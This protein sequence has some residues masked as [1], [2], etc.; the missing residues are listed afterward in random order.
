M[1]TGNCIIETGNENFS[2]VF[3]H[4][5]KKV[6]F[7]K[8]VSIDLSSSKLVLE[9]VGIIELSNKQDMK[10]CLAYQTLQQKNV[11][12]ISLQLISKV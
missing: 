6:F 9:K 5:I 11:L 2:L 4:L 7:N 12:Q 8:I 3:S 1:E 10:L